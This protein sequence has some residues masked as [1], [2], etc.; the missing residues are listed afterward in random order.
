MASGL[1]SRALADRPSWANADT[2]GRLEF[3]GE[4]VDL[5]VPRDLVAKSG[6]EEQGGEDR[7]IAVPLMIQWHASVAQRGRDRADE[8]LEV[9]RDYP[10]CSPLARGQGP[11]LW[12]LGIERVRL[13]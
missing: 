13:L 8:Q 9:C 12:C 5:P 10:A 6:E 2:P 11:G 1:P 7:L 4:P 3:L